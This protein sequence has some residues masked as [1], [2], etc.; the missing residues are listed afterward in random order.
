MKFEYDKVGF[1]EIKLIDMGL[2][3]L[4]QIQQAEKELLDMQL[5]TPGADSDF[6][7]FYATQ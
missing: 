4:L 7:D 3:D 1:D 5:G 6:T 2:G